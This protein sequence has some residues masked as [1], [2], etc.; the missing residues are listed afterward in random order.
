MKKLT[1]FILSLAMLA[2]FAPL[3]VTAQTKYKKNYKNRDNYSRQYHGKKKN[4]YGRNRNLINIGIGAG[5]GAI[6]GGIMGGKRGA[7]IGAGVGAGA[8]AAYTYGI[9]PKKKQTRRYYRRN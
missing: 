9:N 4:F 7:L 1:A 5:A 8:G 2:V 6:V 3:T